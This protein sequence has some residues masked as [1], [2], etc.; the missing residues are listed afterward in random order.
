MN[1]KTTFRFPADRTLR[2]ETQVEPQEPIDLFGSG[3]LVL[4]PRPR[5]VVWLTAG[6]GD[7]KVS[8][9]IDAASLR[10]LRAVLAMVPEGG[11]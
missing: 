9:E 6:D 8:I 2:I 7:N 11:E 10:G 4:E 3:V 1:F 5:R